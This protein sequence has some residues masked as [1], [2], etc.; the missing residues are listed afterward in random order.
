M[1][2]LKIE[3]LSRTI[4]T[5][6]HH[7]K[8]HLSFWYGTSA[9][10]PSFQRNKLAGYY[11]TLEGK[12]KYQGPF[13]SCG[14]PLLDYRGT[15]GC[16]YNP[17]AISQYGLGNYNLYKQTH[18][19]KYLKCFLKAVDWLITNLEKNKFGVYNWCYHFD[20]EYGGTTL[21]SP[22]ISCLAQGEGIS[23]LVRAYT[24]TNKLEYLECAKQAYLSFETSIKEGGVL[25]VDQNGYVWLEEAIVSP[26]TNILNGF[27]SAIWGIYD[28]YLC[29]K[30]QIYLKSFHRFIDTLKVHLADYDCF[31]WSL[32]ERPRGRLKMVASPSYHAL[33]V[34]Q[35]DVLYRLT[36]ESIFQEFHKKWNIYQQS[37]FNRSLAVTLRTFHK[38]IKY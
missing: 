29:T 25:Y 21:K 7:S 37:R 34:K 3:N 15:V 1:P 20:W 33:H 8:S 24:L 36:G 22:W 32:Y 28:L 18:E 31:F 11:L 2:F 38:I 35:L 16:C 23:A 10:N 13:D 30:E 27:I 6:Y 9:V 5:L 26:P 12:A 19:D 14:I 4:S 17:A